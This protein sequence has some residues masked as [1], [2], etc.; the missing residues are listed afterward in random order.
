MLQKS[1]LENLKLPRL[2]TVIDIVFDKRKNTIKI[3]G[4]E[5]DIVQR[6]CGYL[7]NAQKIKDRL[8]FSGWAVDYENETPAQKVLIFVDEKIVAEAKPDTVRA[9]IGATNDAFLK[10]GFNCKVEDWCSAKV[11]RVSVYAVFKDHKIP[12]LKYFGTALD[13][14]R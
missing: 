1:K 9:D 8:N 12:E 13:F 11:S 10:S 4:V 5:H 2:D 7:D 3:N 14:R 6:D